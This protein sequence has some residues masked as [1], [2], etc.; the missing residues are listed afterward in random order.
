MW[1]VMIV[2]AAFQ[3]RVVGPHVNRDTLEC[4]AQQFRPLSNVAGVHALDVHIERV[5]AD[6]VT[7]TVRRHDGM[8]QVVAR[9]GDTNVAC[10]DAC[11]QLLRESTS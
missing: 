10:R 9:G 7:V 4:V 11:M 5:F 8:A 3:L 2:A 1:L 6:E